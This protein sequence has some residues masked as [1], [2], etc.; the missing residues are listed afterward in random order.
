MVVVG[1]LSVVVDG[2]SVTEVH[3]VTR[4]F[5]STDPNPLAMSY[6]FTALYPVS[7]PYASV[8]V[9]VVQLNDPVAHGIAF[10]P[11]VTS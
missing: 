5:A 4:L 6:P 9:L 10:V 2:S 11:R 3:F 8:A 7:I 1:M